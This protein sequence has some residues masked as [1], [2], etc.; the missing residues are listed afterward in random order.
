MTPLYQHKHSYFNPHLVFLWFNVWILPDPDDP[1]GLGLR[2]WLR[3]DQAR[4][5]QMFGCLWADIEIYSSLDTMVQYGLVLY[6]FMPWHLYSH[7]IHVCYIWWHY[8][9]YTQNV[10]I[11]I[12]TIHGSYGIVLIRDG[13]DG[14][15]FKDQPERSREMPGYITGP[16]VVDDSTNPSWVRP[17]WRV[18]QQFLPC[19]WVMITYLNTIQKLYCV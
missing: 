4:L 17:R 12:Y 10:S 18:A 9:H 15:L 16:L 11:Y 8:H 7:R 5:R 1:H 6:P 2:R 3:V 13:I 14:D 19:P